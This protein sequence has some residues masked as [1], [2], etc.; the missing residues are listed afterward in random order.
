LSDPDRERLADRLVGLI[1]I[2]DLD[3]FD[4]TLVLEPVYDNELIPIVTDVTS[5]RR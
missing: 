2:L 4:P 3:H 1:G 5:L